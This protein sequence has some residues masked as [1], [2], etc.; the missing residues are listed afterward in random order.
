MTQI[1]ARIGLQQR[2]LPAY[3]APLFDALAAAA[4]G[5]LSVFA[6]AAASAGIDRNR[7][8]AHRQPDSRPQP[9]P[10]GRA[11]LSCY[12]AGLIDWL[13]EWQPEVLIAEANPRYLRTPAA[14][15]WMHARR[16]A[17]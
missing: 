2:V 11:F 6:G 5:E 16:T 17:R 4:G 15:R 1:K 8:A 10:V 3:R 12:Q 7:Q 13:E 9:A 14:V